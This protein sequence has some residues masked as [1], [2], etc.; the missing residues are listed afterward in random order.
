MVC[1]RKEVNTMRSGK[2]CP[3]VLWFFQR[4]IGGY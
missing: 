4:D 3:D 2:E 1:V